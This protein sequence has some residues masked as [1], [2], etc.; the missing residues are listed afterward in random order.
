MKKY[1]IFLFIAS[2]SYT[3]FGMKRKHSLSNSQGLKEWILATNKLIEE[4]KDKD[5]DALLCAERFFITMSNRISLKL[6]A[7]EV[8]ANKVSSILAIQNKAYPNYKK[9]KNLS[10]H[11]L[12][13][14][15]PFNLDSLKLF[16]KTQ[17]FIKTLYKV[18]EK[19]NLFYYDSE[20]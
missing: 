17:Y 9:I 7:E 11:E 5:I 19:N 13:D 4:N 15:A 6:L 8:K 2:L 3:A 14:L 12:D 18:M 16:N 1:I 20:K 10:K